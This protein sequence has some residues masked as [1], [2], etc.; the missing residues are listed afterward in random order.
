MITT[1]YFEELYSRLQAVSFNVRQL[2][3]KDF[4]PITDFKARDIYEYPQVRGELSRLAHTV[5]DIGD[6]EKFSKAL[7]SLSQMEASVSLRVLVGLLSYYGYV[8]LV[9]GKSI[10]APECLQ[11]RLLLN[12]INSPRRGGTLLL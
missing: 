5:E 4:T 2:D 7:R 3:I 12:M 11:A 1:T 9:C 6:C 8:H 10:N